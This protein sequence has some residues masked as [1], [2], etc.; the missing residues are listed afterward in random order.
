[1]SAP[2]ATVVSSALIREAS[3]VVKASVRSFRVWSSEAGPL[4][5]R[6]FERRQVARGA[7]DDLAEPLLLLAEPLEQDRHVFLHLALRPL[8]LFGGFVAAGDEKL[9]Q[10]HPRSASFWS[11]LELAAERL[12]AISCPTPRKDSLTL[13]LLLESASRSLAS[14]LIRPRTR[15]SLSL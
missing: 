6:D 8:N 9:G 13:W 7:F 5:D 14:S 2:C 15:S 3:E 1:M 12:R 4:A 10:L 11:M